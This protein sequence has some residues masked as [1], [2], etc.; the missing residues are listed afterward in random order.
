MRLDVTYREPRLLVLGIVMI[1]VAGLSAFTTIGRQEDPVITNLFAM[2][3]TPYP[4][5]EAS[6]VEELLTIP[7]EER[8]R[9]IPEID[10][11]ESTSSADLSVI[12][13]ELSSS[14]A[15]SEIERL[16]TE[17]RNELE[18]ARISYPEGAGASEVDTD[19]TG[20]FAAIIAIS[21]AR[22]DIP[23][24]IIGRHANALALKLQEVPGTSNVRRFGLPDEEIRVE[25]A[26]GTLASLGLTVADVARAI[27]EAD[28]MTRAGRLAND[29]L[30]IKLSAPKELETL[31]DLYNVNL[32]TGDASTLRLGNVAS[33]TRTVREP[34]KNLALHDGE[35]AVLVALRIEDRQRID[36][37]AADIRDAIAAFDATAPEGLK[38]EMIFDQSQQT[39]ERLAEIGQSLTIGLALVMA[40]LF[41]SMG[42][43]SALIVGATIP[44]VGL[45]TIASL[46]WI[47]VPIHQMS[48]TGLIV[49]L[50][51]VVD[52][53]I[54]MVDEIARRIA[55]GQTRSAAVAGAIRRL[56]TPLTASTL[57]TAFAFMPML[58][59]PGAA[60]D[61]IS[62]IAIAVIF[63]LA[64]SLVVALLITSG[65]SGLALQVRPQ[66][67]QESSPLIKSFSR[68]LAWALAHP[69]ITLPVFMAPALFGFAL[70]PTLPMQFFPGVERNQFQVEIHMASGTP[71][72]QTRAAALAVD[73]ALRTDSSVVSVTWMVGRGVPVFY[74]NVLSQEGSA[75]HYAHAMVV[76]RSPEA[77]LDL[78]RR[79]QDDLGAV[80]PAAQVVAR[81]LV[82]GP[83]VTAPVEI[84][85]FGQDVA[86]L[87]ETGEEI[88][89]RMIETPGIIETRP[90]LSG[91]A[92]SVRLEIDEARARALGLDNAMIATQVSDALDGRIGGI[93]HEGEEQV[94]IRV[95]ISEE[96]RQSIKAIDD[97][98]LISPG[99]GTGENH[100]RAAIPL[101]SIAET[102]LT[103]S[104][105]TVAR[106]NGDRINI[107]QAFT[108]ADALPQSVEADLLK[109]L[110]ASGFVPPPGVTIQIGGDSD[111]R[112]E[113]MRDL[114][115]YLGVIIVLAIATVILTFGSFRLAAV[116]AIVC[117]LSVGSS[118]LC[119]SLAGQPMGIMANIGIIGAIGVSINAAIIIITALQADARASGRNTDAVVG[120]VCNSVRHI[121]STTITTFAGFLPLIFA[122]GGFWPPFAVA[123]AGGVLLSTIVSLIVTPALFVLF[124]ASSSRMFGHR[125]DQMV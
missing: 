88:R 12:E 90:S 73:K 4:G 98:Y 51:L 34:A 25:V 96:E 23:P 30:N 60:G 26:P 42:L 19:F 13:V 109:R 6:R 16:W 49:A 20:T 78:L 57:T 18:D 31:R 17:I 124:W 54:V 113:T 40:V 111:A 48:S 83:P 103:Q 68:L 95:M 45:A 47:G 46:N 93:L 118:L 15:A 53:N 85:L 41:V 66:R 22:P 36:R 61:F 27:A 59:L 71:I 74:Y 56:V 80:V 72:D 125:L 114:Q 107:V 121:G 84:R 8:L 87:R 100:S 39:D 122:G 33:I 9:R 79:V 32:R 102:R 94:P 7:I 89:R 70:A 92:P 99:F 44:L 108:T 5:A 38:I 110:E 120:V 67:Y 43:R 69:Q 117:V 86:T 50:G 101:S 115:A 116:S 62:T 77:T 35:D 29:G 123:I 112:A 52:A 3:Q 105:S 65:L 14:V 104:E 2:I 55:S 64:W 11:I 97:F 1:L 91:G 28:G 58:L 75:P 24:A 10:T 63:M 119:L 76:T 106:R 21:A 82:Q 37:W 81:R